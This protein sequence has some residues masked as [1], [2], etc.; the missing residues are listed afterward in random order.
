V[1][2]LLPALVELLREMRHPRRPL[3]RLLQVVLA[4][5]LVTLAV[6]NL[7][8]VQAGMGVEMGWLDHLFLSLAMV[9]LITF[10]LLRPEP[11]GMGRGSQ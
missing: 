9:A 7:W 4:I 10:Q 2:L 6:V 11:G 8:I 5:F 3:E 1:L